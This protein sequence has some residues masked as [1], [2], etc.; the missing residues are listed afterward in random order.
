MLIGKGEELSGGRKRQSNLANCLEA[1]IGGYYVDSGLQPVTKFVL[2]YFLKELNTLLNK[3]SI[4]DSK[5][6]LQELTQKKFREKPKYYLIET[7][8]PDHMRQ[9]KMGVRI[10]NK[11]YG[12]G[13]G[14]TK[15]SAEQHA[16]MVS[17]S[18]LSR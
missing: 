1:I 5:S 7:S 8:G 13:T 16:A 18:K 14:N 4:K 11:L 15:Q 2:K 6:K 10:R 17:L 9:F 3:V 12:V